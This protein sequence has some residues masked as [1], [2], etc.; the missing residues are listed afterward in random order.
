MLVDFKRPA[1]TPTER[2]SQLAK[3]GEASKVSVPNPG[4]AAAERGKFFWWW[5]IDGWF[6]IGL[7]YFVKKH[8]LNLRFVKIVL[9]LWFYIDP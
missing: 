5:L 8:F 1:Q 7:L 3:A 2:L 4:R 9:V 6:V